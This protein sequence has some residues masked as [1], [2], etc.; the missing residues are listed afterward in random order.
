M[1][2]LDDGIDFLTEGRMLG[3]LDEG[4]RL[5]LFGSG[6]FFSLTHFYLPIAVE[7]CLTDDEYFTIWGVKQ[8]VV[9]RF[10]IFEKP[11]R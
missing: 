8:L 3:L 6:R 1:R 5:R 10:R 2:Q 7:G 9:L 11:L 4:L